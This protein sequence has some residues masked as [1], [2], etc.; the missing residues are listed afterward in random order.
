MAKLNENGNGKLVGDNI[1]DGPAALW[2]WRASVNVIFDSLIGF[3]G[4][5]PLGTI[6]DGGQLDGG[7]LNWV[8]YVACWSDR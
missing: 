3:W 7:I 1:T 6:D 5:G 8:S 2:K 4:A